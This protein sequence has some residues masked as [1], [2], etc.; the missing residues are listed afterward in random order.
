MLPLPYNF[1]RIPTVYTDTEYMNVSLP[2]S[3]QSQCGKSWIKGEFIEIDLSQF[4]EKD[5]TDI[6]EQLIL[7][8][9]F[10]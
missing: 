10:T 8:A 7:L 2:F 9:P 5:L 4:T 6:D 3:I 1:N